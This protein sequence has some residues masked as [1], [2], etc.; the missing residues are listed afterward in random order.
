M[1]TTYLVPVYEAC[2]RATTTT[3][4]P[5]PAPCTPARRASSVT[6]DSA[7]L[8]TSTTRYLTGGKVAFVVVF[9]GIRDASGNLLTT[10]PADPADDFAVISPPG[11]T[12]LTFLDSTYAAGVLAGPVRV[13]FDVR[14]GAAKVVYQT[15]DTLPIP[16]GIV[17]E[18]GSVLVVDSEG[19]RLATVGAQSRPV[20]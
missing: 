2:P 6:F 14:K 4:Q 1:S 7:M 18:G 19:K 10:N 16:D 5:S 13:P 20:R 15:P 17:V 3:T 9:R 12:T 11:Q 8:K